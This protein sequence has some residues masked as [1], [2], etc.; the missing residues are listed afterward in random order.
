MIGDFTGP[1]LSGSHSRIAAM[2]TTL[3][4]GFAVL[5]P[6]DMCDVG[7]PSALVLLLFIAAERLGRRAGLP[8][9][10]PRRR[11]GGGQALLHTRLRSEAV[12]RRRHRGRMALSVFIARSR[13]L[14][15]SLSLSQRTG[16]PAARW[17]GP[18]APAGSAGAA[19]QATPTGRPGAACVRA[20][21]QTSTSR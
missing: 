14:S 6:S 16:R 15:L 17:P 18:S 5:L 20:P 7:H 3:I 8:T 21:R 4:T 2:A 12:S 10:L 9:G 1:T 13:Y 11:V 19:P